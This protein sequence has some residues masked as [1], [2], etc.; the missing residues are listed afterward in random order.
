MKSNIYRVI[1][2]MSGTSLDGIDCAYVRI[3]KTPQYNF[4]WLATETIPYDTNWQQ[5]LSGALQLSKEE[6]DQLDQEYTRYLTQ[7]VGDFMKRHSIDAVDAICSHGHTVLHMPEEGVT[8]QIGNQSA[9][10]KALKTRVVCDFRV[11]DV[12][13]GGQGAPLVPIGDQIFFDDYAYCLNLGGIANCSYERDGTRLAYD[14]CPVNT[15]LN[16]L[17]QRLGKS[18]DNGGEV[19]RSGQV[20]NRLLDQ[21]NAL[22]FYHKGPPKSLGMEWI[23][24]QFFPLLE[25]SELAVKDLLATCTEHIAIQISRA[26]AATPEQD[27]L[28]TG[29]GAYNAYLIERM[30]FHSAGYYK[31]PKPQ[32]IDFKEALIFAL[33]GVLRLEGKTNILASV[34]GA[35]HDHSSGKIFDSAG[36]ELLENSEKSDS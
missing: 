1:G 30:R 12:A 33:L 25:Q 9:F 6:R 26:I 31:V 8:L 10:A 28:V 14:I 32:L 36:I 24:A 21:L 2:V 5:Q 23:N 18:F 22:D 11:K 16:A 4:E 34:T 17:A 3:K 35:S 15:V 19:A 13:L 29:G 7:V 20:N 27:I